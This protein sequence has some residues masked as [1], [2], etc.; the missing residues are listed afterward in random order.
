MEETEE[1]ITYLVFKINNNEYAINVSKVLNIIEMQEVIT[2]P[3]VPRVVKGL[4]QLQGSVI[5]LVDLRIRFNAPSENFDEHTNIIIIDVPYENSKTQV[6]AIVDCVTEV[7]D[8]EDNEILP[9]PQIAIKDYTKY[10]KG[11]FQNEQKKLIILNTDVLFTSDEIL[12]FNSHFKEG[13]VEEINQ[14][15]YE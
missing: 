8:I 15:L 4:I 14:N 10:I 5:A 2:I 7:I 13:S 3:D 1:I 11:I 9:T 12:L 6:G